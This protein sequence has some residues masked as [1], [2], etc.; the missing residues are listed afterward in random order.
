[1]SCC[2]LFWWIL[3]MGARWWYSHVE[4]S[5]NMS[6]LVLLVNSFKYLVLLAELFQEKG[7]A[8]HVKQFLLIGRVVCAKKSTLPEY[9]F[10]THRWLAF[11][12]VRM[13]QTL[14]IDAHAC[15]YSLARK[16]S[17]FH[18]SVCMKE[19]FLW[20]KANLCEKKPGKVDASRAFCTG[21][22]FAFIRL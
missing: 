18:Q 15:A 5:L 16:V 2:I 8:L 19:R 6:N 3:S 10:L 1:V 14:P 22:A 4:W 12:L 11:S 21:N 7:N 9:R 20:V 13:W 17:L